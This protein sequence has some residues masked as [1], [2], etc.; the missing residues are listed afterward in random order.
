MQSVR[1]KDFS[2]TLTLST[3]TSIR[4]AARFSQLFVGRHKHNEP[5]TK[6]LV[7]ADAGVIAAKL[8]SKFKNTTWRRVKKTHEH[9]F[10][11]KPQHHSFAPN[12]PAQERG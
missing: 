12:E 3:A 9:N 7:N 4:Q 8:E 11:R 10:R 5:K 2:I 6:S 1:N